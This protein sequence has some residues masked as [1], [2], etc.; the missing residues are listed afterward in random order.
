MIL[1]PLGFWQSGGEDPLFLQT[2]P[3]ATV[4]HSVRQL[5]NTYT[6]NCIKMRRSSDGVEF[7]IGFVNGYIDTASIVTNAAG[8]YSTVTTWYDQSG[9]GNNA[10]QATD[11]I[12]P[13][14]TDVNGAIINAPNKAALNFQTAANQGGILGYPTPLVYGNDSSFF[15]STSV[16]REGTSYVF[17]GNGGG[18]RPAYLSQY[19]GNFEWY[20]NVDRFVIKASGG[21]TTDV[22]QVSVC[23][24]MSGNV[25]AFYEG[26]QAFSNASGTTTGT[27]NLD[28]IGGSGPGSDQYEGQMSEFIIYTTIDKNS[29]Q[30]AMAADQVAYF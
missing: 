29:D 27:R 20:D 8:G 5:S 28:I 18:S 22:Q 9:N 19:A 25:T 2:Y 1:K 13:L 6:G 14:I 17:G 4:A 12:Q 23:L 21:S 24:Q 10:V 3:G 26:A 15:L 30:A 16:A 7:D 11:N